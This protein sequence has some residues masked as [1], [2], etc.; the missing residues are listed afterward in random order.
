MSA[1]RPGAQQHTPRKTALREAPFA[2]DTHAQVMGSLRSLVNALGQSARRLEHRTGLTNAQ[3]FILRQLGHEARLS[4]N[5]LAARAMTQQSAVSLVV[6][7]LAR[8]GLV[9]R[10]RSTVDARRAVITLTPE[11]RRLLRTAPEPPTSRLLGALATLEDDEVDG[12]AIGLRALARAL[13]TDTSAPA[14]LFEPPPNAAARATH[15]NR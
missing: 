13:G 10:S 1:S 5:E 3:L 11:G 8:R 6:S 4:I 15:A 12:L 2:A 9:R 7:R 14:L